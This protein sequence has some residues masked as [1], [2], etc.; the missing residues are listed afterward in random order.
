MK[1]SVFTKVLLAQAVIL[2]SGILLLSRPDASGLASPSTTSTIAV[3]EEGH[4]TTTTS[5][6]K[7]EIEAVPVAIQQQ[8]IDLSGIDWVALARHVYGR[9]GEY[10]H[11]AMAVGW[12]ADQWPKISKVMYRESRC[13]TT[14]FNRTDPNGGSRGLMQVNGFWCRP[15]KYT[16]QGWLQ[17]KGVLSSCEDLFNAETNLRA[18]LHMWLYSQDKNGCGWRPWATSCR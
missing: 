12:P 9:C 15:N 18:S 13:N 5:L 2:T 14:S 17:D 4:P 10:Y 1:K 8:S 11:L 7:Q 6:P 3:V 16:K